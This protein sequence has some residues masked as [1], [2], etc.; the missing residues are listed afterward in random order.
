MPAALIANR[1]MTHKRS[2]QDQE[3]LGLVGT[4]RRLS[5][6]VRE[7]RPLLTGTFRTLLME[8]RVLGTD[9][10][11]R[12]RV[13]QSAVFSYRCGQPAWTIRGPKSSTA[14]GGPGYSQSDLPLQEGRL[15]DIMDA[16]RC[17]HGFQ[18][19]QAI[20]AWLKINAFS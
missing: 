2:G 7:S 1:P 9:G 4:S 12:V 15:G 16:K 19:V 11:L 20:R 6:T 14:Y 13:G 10:R 5:Q 18:S 3:M 17:I 8:S